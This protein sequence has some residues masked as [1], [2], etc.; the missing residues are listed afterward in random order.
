[1]KTK[2]QA[3]LSLLMMA[4]LALSACAAAPETAG[5]QVTLSIVYGSEK[6]EWLAPLVAQFNAERH[7]TA[8]GAIIVVEAAPMGSVEAV[9]LMLDG[10]LQPAVWSPASSVYV[11]V[12]NAEW[13]KKFGHDL[14]TGTPNDLV[15][16]P[17]VIAMW[18]P[19]AEALGWPDRALGWADI[20]ALAA[21]AAS[22][23]TYGYPE[24][25][26]F[27]LGQTYPTFSNSGMVSM[28]AGVYT[29]M[30]KQRDLTL[31]D[32][33]SSRAAELIAAAQSHI[34]Y[35]GNSTGFLAERMFQGGPAYLSAAVLYENLV[36]AQEA[37]RLGQRDLLRWTQEQVPI[38]AIYPKEGTFW[39]NNPYILVNAPWV[40]DEQKAAAAAFEHFLLDRPQQLKALELGFRPA[41]AS[42][43]LTAPLDARH[44]VDVN[45]PQTTLEVPV[46]DVIRAAQGLWGR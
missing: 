24:W 5:P 11:P 32:I 46:A 7:R 44:G 35:D 14:V 2:L 26:R 18:K 38:V 19:M 17:V 39:T 30:Q 12:A 42:I 13:R 29:G 45:Q 37:R 20:T 28:L 4:A 3:G 41:E 8:H 9:A 31:D 15:L 1:M 16:S 6:R 22:W 21:A 25:G 23:E 33:R 27:T 40:T 34:T 36:V 10:Q 43:P